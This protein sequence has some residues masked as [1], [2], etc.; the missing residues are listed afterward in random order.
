MRKLT[1]IVL[2]AAVVL[3]ASGCASKNSL[4][5][6]EYGQRAS[7]ARPGDPGYSGR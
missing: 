2:L 4:A 7:V 5:G 3:I 6:T 1:S